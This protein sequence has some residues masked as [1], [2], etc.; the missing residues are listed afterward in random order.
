MGLREVCEEVGELVPTGM[1]VEEYTTWVVW[2][3]YA[4]KRNCIWRAGMGGGGR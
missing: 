2:V 3:L 1:G 4:K